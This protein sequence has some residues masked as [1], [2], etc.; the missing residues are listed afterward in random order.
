MNE[1]HLMD[2]EASEETALCNADVSVLDLTGVQAYLERRMDR[3]SVS[4]ICSRCKALAVRWI[5]NHLRHLEADARQTRVNVEEV[6]KMSESYRTKAESL[7]RQTEEAAKR[8]A[9]HAN[10]AER[11]ELDAECLEDDAHDYRQ[12]AALLE[13]EVLAEERQDR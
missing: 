5:E 3:L 10:S 8:A 1:M 6:R 13:R 12:V 4:T 2:T 9:G 11:R 7:R